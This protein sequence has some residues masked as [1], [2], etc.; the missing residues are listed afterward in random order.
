[1]RCRRG[2]LASDRVRKA[3]GYPNVR[4]M[5]ETFRRRREAKAAAAKREKLGLPPA[6]KRGFTAGNAPD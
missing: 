3:L 1:M 5:Q 2:G 6:S 4:A